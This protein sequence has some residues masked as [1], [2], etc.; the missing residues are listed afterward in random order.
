[1]PARFTGTDRPS[2]V[3]DWRTLHRVADRQAPTVEQAFVALVAAARGGK[4]RRRIQR[5]LQRGNRRRALTIAVEAWQSASETWRTTL[6]DALRDTVLA[7]ATAVGIRMSQD[8]RITFQI[9]FRVTNPAAQ[10]WAETQAGRL[11]RRITADQRQSIRRVIVQAFTENLTTRQA[12]T[13]I[14]EQIG[15]QSRQAVALERVR[16]DL[17]EKGLTK[18]RIDQVVTRHRDRMIRRRGRSIARTE[19]LRAS[20]MGQ[21]LLWEAAVDAGEWRAQDVRRVFI[22]TPDDRLCPIC[23][24]LDGMLVGLADEFVSPTNG[25]SALVPPLHPSCRCAVGIDTALGVQPM[26][27]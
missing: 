8:P 15:L 14:A 27:A 18:A 21:Q 23:A 2:W 7:S 16:A 11:I 22:V 1:M 13:R 3:T 5:A 24:P 19:V 4:T 25:A 26:A 20:N 12:A 17:V 10:R 9:A 6:E